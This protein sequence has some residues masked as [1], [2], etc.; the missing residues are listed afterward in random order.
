MQIYYF[1]S[2]GFLFEIIKFAVALILTT[3]L[4]HWVT[5]VLKLNKDTDWNA[6]FTLALSWTI[7]ILMITGLGYILGYANLRW[8]SYL[9]LPIGLISVFIRRSQLWE[10][11][12]SALSAIKNADKIIMGIASLG[13]LAQL[14]ALISSGFRYS[15]GIIYHRLNS[16]DGLLHLAFAEFTKHNFPP[17]QPGAV[18][19]FITN[20]HYWSDLYLSEFSRIFFLSTN[21]LYFQFLPIIIS[22]S[23]V[24]ATIQLVRQLGGSVTVQR[25][26]LF[27]HFFAGNAAYIFSKI[28][29]GSWG[30]HLPAIDHGIL[31]YFNMPQA[32][33]RL[34]F[35]IGIVFF[36]KY[37]RSNNIKHGLIMAVFFAT[38]FGFKIYWGIFA[39]LGLS[40]Y[41]MLEGLKLGLQILKTRNIQ[42]ISS[43]ATLVIS[44]VVFGVLALIIF[45]PVNKEAG[46][47]FLAPFFWPKLLLGADN[48]DFNEWWLRLQVYEA[49]RNTR[50]LVVWYGI[51]TAIFLMA[52]YGTR[53]LGLIPPVTWLKDKRKKPF[54]IF[55]WPTAFIFTALGMNVLQSSGGANVFNFFILSLWVSGIILSFHLAWLKNKVPHVIYAAAVVT[56]IV[57]SVPRPLQDLYL[58]GL[59]TTSHAEGFVI[60]PAEEEALLFVKHNTDQSAI[61][62]TLPDLRQDNFETPYVSLFTN[63]QS[64]M[65][66][67]NILLSHNQPVEDRIELVEKIARS[68]TEQE[69][70]A[71]LK[72]ADID[73]LYLKNKDIYEYNWG[74]SATQS[75]TLKT[76]FENE[77]ITVINVSD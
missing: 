39:V 46:G 54:F 71:L 42:N 75:S 6:G 45:L 66:G 47:L 56:I 36:L 72:I 21:H 74:S 49:A 57:F 59:S 15:E 37:V 40:I 4:G 12:G 64:Y 29:N 35:I 10:L 33:A 52:M 77:E 70:L 13:I 50:A 8:L 2:V 67:A 34:I 30:W 53:L 32:Y 68:S 16:V 65:A 38:L 41:L 62:Q 5:S 58:F 76:I 22:I 27:F 17:V 69:L 48:L 73:L 19:L 18:G 28:I 60:S 14:L 51:A 9:I 44:Y 24:I 55:A 31:Q 3:A 7:S 25:W 20:Y 63:R 1:F 26:A 11:M 43:F 61:I 23:L